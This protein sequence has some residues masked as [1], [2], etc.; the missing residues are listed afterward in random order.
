[1][2]SFLAAAATCGDKPDHW[3]LHADISGQSSTWSILALVN[4]FL[5]HTTADAEEGDWTFSR[6]DHHLPPGQ[7]PTHPENTTETT[8]WPIS[9]IRAVRVSSAQTLDGWP[10]RD[11]DEIA[12]SWDLILDND[13]AITLRP[14]TDANHEAGEALVRAVLA[15]MQ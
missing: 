8:I 15:A 1:M 11:D 12:A 4:G 5:I 13:Q 3:L 2:N 7:Q 6:F 9:R 14:R 10:R